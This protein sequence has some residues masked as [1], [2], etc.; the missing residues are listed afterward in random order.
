MGRRRRPKGGPPSSPP[1][2]FPIVLAAVPL[3]ESTWRIAFV[4]VPHPVWS[5]AHGK[6]HAFHAGL[7]PHHFFSPFSAF[8]CF[9]LDYGWERRGGRHPI[10][11]T[12]G[13]RGGWVAREREAS[14]MRCSPVWRS[15]SAPHFLH[16]LLLFFGSDF[17]FPCGR[18]YGF[19]PPLP[20]HLDPAHGSAHCHGDVQRRRRRK[21][22]RK[23]ADF[24]LPAV[25]CGCSSKSTAKGNPERRGTEGGEPQ[26]EEEAKEH[27]SKEKRP[28]K[29][30][31]TNAA[32]AKARKRPQGCSASPPP[33]P[34][35]FCFLLSLFPS[36]SLRYAAP[37]PPEYFHDSTNCCRTATLYCSLSHSPEEVV[38]A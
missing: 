20:C 24:F 15:S 26:V 3:W 37:P 34:L 17:L 38:T 30:E 23:P 25:V 32:E 8:L 27:Q 22:R 33:S 2:P 31:T 36:L 7:L 35:R 9:V 29:K 10:A 14:W 11:S 16:L 13:V 5:L 19:A 1:S 4:L 12:S 28:H 18:R 21:K 6:R